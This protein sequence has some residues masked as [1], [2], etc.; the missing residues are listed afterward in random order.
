MGPGTT[1][2]SQA[3]GTSHPLSVEEVGMCSQVTPQ[4]RESGWVSV[5]YALAEEVRVGP[6]TTAVSQAVGMSLPLSSQEVEDKV[7][8]EGHP[9][10]TGSPEG[11]DTAPFMSLLRG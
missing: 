6:G 4:Q 2:E 1:A 9:K 8:D 5:S 3:V 7:S 11:E 10:G